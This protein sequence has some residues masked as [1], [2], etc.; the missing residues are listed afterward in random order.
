MMPTVDFLKNVR[1]KYPNLKLHLEFGSI[2]S[3]QVRS[4]VIRSVLPT[5]HSLG[6]N[7]VELVAVFRALGDQET[8]IKLEE[9]NRINVYIDVL[10]LLIQ[11]TGI[12]RI[13]FHHL[14]YYISVISKQYSPIQERDALISASMV[15]LNRAT[16][17]Q[18]SNDL[19]KL[20]IVNDFGFENGIMEQLNNFSESE[21]FSTYDDYHIIVVPTKINPKP[22]FT[23]SL[24]DTISS[25]AF[26]LQ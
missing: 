25:I 4:E 26:L 9:S 8:A 18:V 13:H 6:L 21:G 17:G 14:G 11:I 12:S 1:M 22:I 16:T 19:S 20:K 5:V 24:G 7:E 23:V 2:Q 10:R 15:A 3:D